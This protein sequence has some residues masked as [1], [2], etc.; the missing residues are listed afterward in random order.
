M[1]DETVLS[2]SDELERLRLLREEH[3]IT[4]EAFEAARRDENQTSVALAN[5]EIAFARHVYGFLGEAGENEMVNLTQRIWRQ[6]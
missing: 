4:S 1:S 6:R 5:A 3:K 2:L